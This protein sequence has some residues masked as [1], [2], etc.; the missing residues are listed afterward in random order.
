MKRALG[1]IPARYSS[2]RFPGK[3]LASL[4]GKPLVEHVWRRLAL[5]RRID[6]AVVATD[7]ERI[8]SACRAFGAEVFMTS[9]GHVSGT[10]RVAEVAATIGERFDVIVNVQGDEPFVSASSVDRLVAAFDGNPV[11]EMATLVEPFRDADDLFD[12]NHA[13]VV[14]T[15]DGRALYFS[16]APIPYYRGAQQQLV[17]DYR[18]ALAARPGGL[19]GYWKHQG[20][21]AYRP[22]VLG[23]LTRTAPSPLEQDEGLEQLRALQAGYTIRVVESDFRSITVDTPADLARAAAVLALTEAD[24]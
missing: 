23:E 11:P 17:E 7:D 10:D 24:A 14:T 9:A 20:I 12:P 8:A 13:K 3:P 16:R 2:I 15:L 1:V 19:A 22:D 5:A 21:Y 18:A 4:G 6:R